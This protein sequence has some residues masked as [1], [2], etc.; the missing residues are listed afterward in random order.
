ASV[1][2]TDLKSAETLAASVAQLD[3]L[4]VRL[5]LGEH[6]DADFA[7]ADLLI[8]NP[9]VP[10]T[11]P[12]LAKARAAGVPLDTE[13]NLFFK[14]CPATI[15]GVTGSNG[16]STTVSLLHHILQRGPRQAW[17]GGNIGRSLLEDLDAIGRDHLV[18]LE[19]SSFQLE[20][21][22]ATGLSPAVSVV[23]NISDNHLD[24][25]GTLEAYARA[26]QPIVSNQHEGD[27]AF[28]N[29]DCP[30]VSTWAPHC[31]GTVLFFSAQRPL[32]RGMWLDGERVLWRRDGDAQP[33]F[34]RA[35]LK[36]P[37]P[38]FLADAMAAAG[39]AALCGVEPEAVADAVRSFHGLEHRLEFVRELDGVRY[40][41]DSKATTAPAAIAALE[42]FDSPVVLIAGG[43][44]K[45]LDYHEFGRTIC[46]RARAAVLLGQTGPQVRQAIEA[47]GSVPIHM[48]DDLPG[49]VLQARRVAQPGDVVVLSPA[50]ASYDMFQNFEER[51][52]VFKR[53]VMELRP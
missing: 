22:E 47:H 33:L 39:A 10:D 21:L 9:A 49:A 52:A 28:L 48:M 42:A 29:A 6:V 12:Y 36:L 16:K 38:H 53:L 23:L 31:P 46:S 5:R 8:V 43:S 20:R 45:K 32:E 18:V 17:L 37:G 34:A 15:V 41:N 24:R 35:D 13:I 3:G 25:H 4:P 19:L 50:T 1:T 30:I 7:E 40:Y 2:V 11:S 26:K 51:G 27:V 14:L 44:D